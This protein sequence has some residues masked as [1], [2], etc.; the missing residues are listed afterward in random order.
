[1]KV[2]AVLH[3]N[4]RN[5]WICHLLILFDYYSAFLLFLPYFFSSTSCKRFSSAQQ[6]FRARNSFYISAPWT[7]VQRPWICVQ[8]PWTYIQRPWTTFITLQRNICNSIPPNLLAQIRKKVL[9]TQRVQFFFKQTRINTQNLCFWLHYQ[10]I[11]LLLQQNRF[12][13]IKA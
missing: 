3:K 9:R 1:M 2:F 13:Y 5:N 8:R 10:I 6:M 11:C 12:N 4:Y 7:H